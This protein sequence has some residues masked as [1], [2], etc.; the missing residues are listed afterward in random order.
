MPISQM[1]KAEAASTIEKLLYGTVAITLITSYYNNLNDKGQK[2]SLANTQQQTGVYDNKEVQ[3]RITELQTRLTSSGLIK[4]NYAIYANP[5]K[6]LNAFCTLGHVI[7]INKG[8]FD[9]LDDDELGS[10]HGP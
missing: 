3:Q 5:K 2:E 4:A 7:S 9:S 6:E 1:R 8:T 10:Y